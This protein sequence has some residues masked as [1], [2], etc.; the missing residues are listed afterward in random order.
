MF[1]ISADQFRRLFRLADGYHAAR[2]MDLGAGDGATTS[3]LASMFDSVDVTEASWP[4][5]RILA[6]KGFT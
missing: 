1:V 2:L 4:M 5:K 6:A 3:L